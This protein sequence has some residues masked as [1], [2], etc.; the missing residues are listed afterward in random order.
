MVILILLKLHTIQVLEDRNVRD[1]ECV[2]IARRGT[3]I[4]LGWAD[5]KTHW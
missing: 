5:R 2:S 4:S 3:V 1:K